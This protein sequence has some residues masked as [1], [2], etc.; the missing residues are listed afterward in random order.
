MVINEEY[1]AT[2]HEE[3]FLQRHKWPVRSLERKGRTWVQSQDLIARHSQL[4]PA[5]PEARV[6]LYNVRLAINGGN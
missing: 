3:R 2:G 5:P 4:I 1:A 6:R